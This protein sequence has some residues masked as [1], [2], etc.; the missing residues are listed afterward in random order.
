MITIDDRD[1]QI[2]KK[3]LDYCEEVDMAI[4]RFGRTY[5][6]FIADFAFCNCVSMS[7]MQIG[8]LVKALSDEFLEKHDNIPWHEIR[9]MRNWFAHSYQKMNKEFIWN[10]ATKDIPALR[11]F[12]ESVLY[13]DT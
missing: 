7:E 13:S 12:C 11:E 6:E 2:I 5:E 1:F 10:V 8:E 3:I 9:A 4:S